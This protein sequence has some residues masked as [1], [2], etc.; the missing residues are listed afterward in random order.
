MT[1]VLENAEFRGR[2]MPRQ[3]KSQRPVASLLVTGLYSL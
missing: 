1:Q 3:K 2:A